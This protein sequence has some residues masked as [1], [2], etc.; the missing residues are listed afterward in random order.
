MEATASGVGE[1]GLE[2]GGLEDEGEGSGHDRVGVH[3]VLL[4][5]IGM[6]SGAGSSGRASA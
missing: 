2:G 3:R 1:R 4:S 5:L 6:L